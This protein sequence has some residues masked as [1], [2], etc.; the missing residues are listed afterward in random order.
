MSV[1]QDESL[2]PRQDKLHY[3]MQALSFL[4]LLGRE[5][6]VPPCYTKVPAYTE[7]A[8]TEF[9]KGRK[10]MA[11]NDASFLLQEVR[12][13]FHGCMT[14]CQSWEGD[15]RQSFVHSSLLSLSEVVLITVKLLC[16][17]GHWALASVL[18]D[19]V[20]R[21]VVRNDVLHS[22]IVALGKLSVTIYS[23]G[24]SGEDIGHC[25]TMCVRALRCI[26]A[27]LGDRESHAVV[28]ASSL[29]QWAV[30]AAQ[31]GVLNAPNLLAWFSSLEEHQERIQRR[32]QMVSAAATL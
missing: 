25:L 17:E 30:E 7:Q 20:D 27:D 23:S 15:T 6:T 24:S 1:A 18:L 19:E 3:Q 28:Q 26:P 13:L 14:A 2:N 10:A 9:Q 21:E 4:L 29:V 32:I 8:F 12:H 16:K 11:K 31:P 5:I 22:T